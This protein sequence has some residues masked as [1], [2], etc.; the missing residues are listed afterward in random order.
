MTLY[1]HE[2]ILQKFGGPVVLIMTIFIVLICYFVISLM[3]S[4]VSYPPV[5]SIPPG[6]ILQQPLQQLA[7]S[8]FINS[9]VSMPLLIVLVFIIGV[10]IYN[11]IDYVEGWEVK[12]TEPPLRKK[13]FL[14]FRD[15]R[16]LITVVVMLIFGLWCC[17]FMQSIL[18]A[19]PIGPDWLAN[20]HEFEGAVYNA[21]GISPLLP[22]I[23]LGCLVI[24]CLLISSLNFGEKND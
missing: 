16:V 5:V 14:F 11:L 24:L 10:F 6:D 20:Q 3:S 18:M 19:T 2:W 22:G 17:F 13:I 8:I 1:P 7:P 4:P 15:Y 23:L 9:A 12:I 21:N